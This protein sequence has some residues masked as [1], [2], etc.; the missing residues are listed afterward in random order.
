MSPTRSG[1]LAHLRANMQTVELAVSVSQFS[2]RWLFAMFSWYSKLSIIA[3]GL[4]R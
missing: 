3:S 4:P 1:K 2:L